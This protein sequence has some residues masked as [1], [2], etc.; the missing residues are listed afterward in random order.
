MLHVFVAL[1]FSKFISL[2]FLDLYSYFLVSQNIVSYAANE[3]LIFEFK[4][5]LLYYNIKK[6]I[7]QELKYIF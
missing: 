1:F 7:I 6:K 4:K 3:S 5:N 2:V